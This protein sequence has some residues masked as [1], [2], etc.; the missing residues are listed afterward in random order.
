MPVNIT[1]LK[2]AKKLAD[3]NK[4]TDKIHKTNK[5]EPLPPEFDEILANRVNFSSKEASSDGRLNHNGQ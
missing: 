2:I 1:E 5:E 3:F 4:L